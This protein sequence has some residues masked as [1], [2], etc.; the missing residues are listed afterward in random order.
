MRLGVCNYISKQKMR[1]VEIEAAMSKIK[2]ELDRKGAKIE[3]SP[4]NELLKEEVITQYMFYHQIPGETFGSKMEKLNLAIEER[5]LILCRLVLHKYEDAQKRINDSQGRLTS[6][7][8]KNIVGDVVDTY[9]KGELIQE[10]DHYFLLL[11]NMMDDSEENFIRLDVM[12][13]KISQA[14]K[15]L[16]DVRAVWSVSSIG[17]SW[18]ELYEMYQE[19]CRKME[20]ETRQ[21]S[22]E[23][24]MATVQQLEHNIDL[25][26]REIKVVTD[27]LISTSVLNNLI[28]VGKVTQEE[29]IQMEAQFVREVRNVLSQYEYVESICFYNSE[30]LTM[31]VDQEQNLIRNGENER[32]VF[33]QEQLKESKYNNATGIYWHGGYTNY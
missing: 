32:G 12:L 28:F 4:Q 8:V 19:C 3:S 2:A 22:V 24:D 6:F 27:R 31:I 13:R 9:G 26:N 18:K 23:I 11:M 29:L 14:L 33:F 30:E 20:E 21:L 25:F 5:N 7:M 15:E 1:P 10:K 16:L 17:Q